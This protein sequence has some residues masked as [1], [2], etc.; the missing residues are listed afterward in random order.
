MLATFHRPTYEVNGERFEGTT[1]VRSLLGSL[2][3]AFPDLHI[4][5]SATHHTESYLIGE[6]RM[7]GTHRGTFIGVAATGRRIDLPVIGV[8]EFEADRL[9]N[10]RIT[11]DSGTL[12][13]QLGAFPISA[14]AHGDRS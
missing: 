14:P 3:D 2:F 11:F 9:V 4:E 7:T 1:A 10:E 6:G 12:F 13:R 8:F 5:P